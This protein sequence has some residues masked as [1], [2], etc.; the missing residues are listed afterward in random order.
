MAGAEC[1]ASPPGDGAGLGAVLLS[2]AGA[3]GDSALAATGGSGGYRPAARMPAMKPWSSS[4]RRHATTT[5]SLTWPAK[6]NQA[7]GMSPNDRERCYRERD[8][9]Q[10]D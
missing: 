4:S 1:A 6:S 9:V 8:R 2:A 3:A 5:A 7:H 10:K